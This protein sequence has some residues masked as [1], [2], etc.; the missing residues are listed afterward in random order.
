MH[1]EGRPQTNTGEQRH[2][3]STLSLKG[4]LS[5]ARQRNRGWYKVSLKSFAFVCV[6]EDQET[7]SDAIGKAT[8]TVI[9][10]VWVGV[11]AKENK[12]TV[13]SISE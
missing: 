10:K 12:R 6:S 11:G 1:P 13:L 4:T 8:F 5:K 9:S 7:L 2:P 3:F